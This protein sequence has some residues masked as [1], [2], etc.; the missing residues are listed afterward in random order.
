MAA[1]CCAATCS[2]LPAQHALDNHMQHSVPNSV[3]IAY[4]VCGSGGGSCS[5]NDLR[6]AIRT[7]FCAGSMHV[8]THTL[9]VS[10]SFGGSTLI[11]NLIECFAAS[12]ES[13][14]WACRSL[15]ALWPAS[16]LAAAYLFSSLNGPSPARMEL[17]VCAKSNCSSKSLVKAVLRIASARAATIPSPAAASIAISLAPSAESS[18]NNRF[19]PARHTRASSK[20]RRNISAIAEVVDSGRAIICLSRIAINSSDIFLYTISCLACSSQ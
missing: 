9:L 20:F 16:C 12:E 2:A 15:K 4:L 7:T 10:C 3:S 17:R 6:I 5:G 18:S 8:S 13:L 14:K 1:C 11:N 19:R